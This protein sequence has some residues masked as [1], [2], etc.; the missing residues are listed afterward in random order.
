MAYSDPQ[1]IS[2]F[3]LSLDSVYGNTH[4]FEDLGYRLSKF[5][6]SQDYFK[7]T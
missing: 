2:D 1:A 5:T 3:R 6:Q 7:S 4:L